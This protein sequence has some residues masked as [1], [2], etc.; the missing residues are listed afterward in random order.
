MG[1]GKGPNQKTVLV[2]PVQL[3][4]AAY[5]DVLEA[6]D[7][8]ESQMPGLGARFYADLDSVLSRIEESRGQFPIVYRAAHRAL[9]HRF[10]FGVFFTEFEDRTL[11]VAVADLRR[12]TSRWQRRI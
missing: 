1:R 10:P 11:V 2:I 4:P 7:W 5:R 8:Y 9:L 12:E 6:V 3:R